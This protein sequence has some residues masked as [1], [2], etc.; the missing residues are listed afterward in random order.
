MAT[1]KVAV[2]VDQHLLHELDRWVAVG[3]FPSRSTAVQIALTALRE[4]RAKHALLDELATLDP[5]EERALAD[6]RLAGEAAW[7]A[8]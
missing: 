3:E 6:E 7:P 4:Q 1:A 2:S 8:S 5:A